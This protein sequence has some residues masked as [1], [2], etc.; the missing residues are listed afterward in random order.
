[1]KHLLGQLAP[2]PTSLVYQQNN[3]EPHIPEL[4]RLLCLKLVSTVIHLHCPRFLKIFQPETFIK[5]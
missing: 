1:M 2:N 3:T 4:S 5:N